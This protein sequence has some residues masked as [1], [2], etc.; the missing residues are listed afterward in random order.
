MTLDKAK[1]RLVKL[2]GFQSEVARRAGVTKQAVSL[3]IRGLS[4]SARIEA[5][6]RE[7]CDELA[8]QPEAGGRA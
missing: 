6:V 4:T 8:R 2:R 1:K 3:V 5:A 7:Y